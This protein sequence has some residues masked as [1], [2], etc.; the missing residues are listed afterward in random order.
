MKDNNLTTLTGISSYLPNATVPLC[1]L[2]I[3]LKKWGIL[4]YIALETAII[5]FTGGKKNT[6]LKIVAEKE[7]WTIYPFRCFF[8]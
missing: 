8:G 3:L 5:K 2:E 4:S 6:T 1:D 7:C